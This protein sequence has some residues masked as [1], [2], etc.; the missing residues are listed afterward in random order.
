MCSRLVRIRST[1]GQAFIELTIVLPIM[2]ILGFGAVEFG[3]AFRS[4]FV[5]THVTRE[6]GSLASRQPG[7]K[8][9]TTWANSLNSDLLAVINSATPVIN[10]SGSGATGPNQ[11]N[12]IYSQIEWNTSLPACDYNLDNTLGL[13][14]LGTIAGVPDRYRIRR[15]NSGWAGSVTWTYGSLGSA[16]KIGNNAECACKKLPEV[17]QLSTQGLTLHVIELYY[18]YAPL[19]LTTLQ[20]FLGNSI[21][22]IL[23]RRSVFMDRV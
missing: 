15:S 22:G 3:N 1:C 2:L 11:Y 21:L 18:N 12:L 14:C 13:G 23:Y 4:T 6:A 5:L 9:T 7:T 17:K 16:S 19:K 20:N 10:N 8:G